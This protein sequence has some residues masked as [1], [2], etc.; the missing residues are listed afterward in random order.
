MMHNVPFKSGY[1]YDSE[2]NTFTL[3][4]IL[5]YDG[6]K[7]SIEY[8]VK[9]LHGG[10][11]HAPVETVIIPIEDLRKVEYRGKLFSKTLRIEA[12]S[13]QYFDGVPGA[14]NGILTV[15]VNSKNKQGA[16]L[17]SSAVNLKISEIR[18]NRLSED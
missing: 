13:L 17:L 14:D 4:G 11:K 5:D 1:L 12:K 9:Y 6:H 18:L 7:L 15:P 2:F 16:Q 3:E 10:T 8:K